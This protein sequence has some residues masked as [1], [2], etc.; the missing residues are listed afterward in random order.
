M[1]HRKTG[2]QET[3]NMYNTYK[4]HIHTGNITQ[5]N[6]KQEYHNRKQVTGIT[7]KH[8]N[9]KTGNRKQETLQQETLQQVSFTNRKNCRGNRTQESNTRNIAISMTGT[10]TNSTGN[11]EHYTSNIET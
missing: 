9:I 11:R 7:N 5:E 3:G 6:S 2:K 10:G 8:Y 4:I 1:Q